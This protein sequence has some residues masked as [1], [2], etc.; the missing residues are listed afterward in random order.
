MSR[1]LQP[2]HLK[3]CQGKKISNKRVLLLEKPP[4]MSKESALK[5]R[6]LVA[7]SLSCYYRLKVILSNHV[8][9]SIEVM[10]ELNTLY[11]QELQ[12]H[13]GENDKVAKRFSV[14]PTL[15]LFS[16]IMRHN[17]ENL[18]FRELVAF[19]PP[20]PPHSAGLSLC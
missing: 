15:N 2:K 18:N 3:G 9:C 8:P 20:P 17:S 14:I 12:R 19:P 11:S 1:S 7:F 5:R 4:R 16:R 6:N 10:L 13:C